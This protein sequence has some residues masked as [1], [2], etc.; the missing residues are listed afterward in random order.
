MSAGEIKIVGAW[1]VTVG[2]KIWFPIIT[3]WSALK[4]KL[5]GSKVEIEE[6]EGGIPQ[7]SN[8]RRSK[9]A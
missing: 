4:L 7:S 8:S 2:Q 3:F 5:Q 9:N 1:M 6:G